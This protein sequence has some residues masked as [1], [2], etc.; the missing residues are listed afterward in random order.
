MKKYLLKAKELYGQGGK[1]EARQ[2]DT[3]KVAM[4]LWRVSD[5]EDIKSDNFKK[6]FGDWENSPDKASK[7]IGRK[8][9]NRL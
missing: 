5:S 2:G 7:V 3:V 4:R 1:A 8:T 6:W 9:V